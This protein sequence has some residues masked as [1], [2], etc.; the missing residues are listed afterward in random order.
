MSRDFLRT[1]FN[2]VFYKKCNEIFARD[3]LTQFL[4]KICFTR[5]FK[6][7]IFT[8]F[9]HMIFYWQFCFGWFYQWGINQRQQQLFNF[10][11][12]KCPRS[13]LRHFLADRVSIIRVRQQKALLLLNSLHGFWKE[14][15]LADSIAL[16]HV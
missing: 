7:N 2:K 11:T 10:F 4:V 12:E 8:K 3:F 14:R 5:I 16:V 13:S 6:E 9:L 1:F 15:F